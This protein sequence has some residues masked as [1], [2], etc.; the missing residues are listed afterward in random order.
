MLMSGPSSLAAA[1]AARRGQ[2]R[3]RWN[4]EIEQAARDGSPVSC[5]S[6]A[7]TSG[8][9]GTAAVHTGM[10][11]SS[12][13]LT[14]LHSVDDKRV[15]GSSLSGVRPDLGQPSGN[16]TTYR[17]RSAIAVASAPIEYGLETKPRTPRSRISWT[18]S[19]SVLPDIRST[20]TLLSISRSAR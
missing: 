13:Y 4:L 14:G 5:Q 19:F 15:F 16:R 1:G 2:K 12:K 10:V 3:A 20:A 8:I 9:Q 11:L 17:V 6:F 7:T 18:C